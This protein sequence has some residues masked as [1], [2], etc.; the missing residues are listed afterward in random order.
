[1]ATFVP[2]DEIFRKDY[3]PPP[4]RKRLQ[5]VETITLPNKYFEGMPVSKSKAKARRLKIISEGFAK[6]K[7][8]R[9]NQ[10]KKDIAAEIIL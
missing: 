5:D 10:M 9:L 8:S 7:I 3:I 6:E 1:L 2:E 4:I